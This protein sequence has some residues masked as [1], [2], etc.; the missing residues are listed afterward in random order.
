MA[1]TV[2]L[3]LL[4]PLNGGEGAGK[5]FLRET[6]SGEGQ[7]ILLPGAGWPKGRIRLL[8]SP[9]SEALREKL[10]FQGRIIE[11]HLLGSWEAEMGPPYQT[12]RLKS[13]P[14]QHPYS[15]LAV[16]DENDGPAHLYHGRWMPPGEGNRSNPPACRGWRS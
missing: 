5:V 3:L 1:T 2:T 15:L 10:V 14:S 6:G 11:G 9:W 8:L 16:V 12:G 4:F 13:C 7:I